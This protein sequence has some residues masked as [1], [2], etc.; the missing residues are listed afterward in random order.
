MEGHPVNILFAEDNDSHAKLVLR[1]LRDH[2]VA[3][4]VYHVR[5]GEA[6]LDFVFQRGPYA[7]PEQAPRPDIVLLD[8]RLPRVDG[9]DVL[10]EIK[11]SPDVSSI[12][13][14]ILTTSEAEKDVAQAYQLHANSYLVKPIDF[15]S[16]TKMLGDLGYYW[17]AWNKSPYG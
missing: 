4:T 6:A 5:D 9:M 15:A 17:L 10:R 11:E 13:V 16:L 8:L 7:D 3:N 14:V 2:S 12:P 1:S